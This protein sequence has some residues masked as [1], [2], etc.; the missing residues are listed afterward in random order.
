MSMVFRDPLLASSDKAT[1]FCAHLGGRA[2]LLRLPIVRDYIPHFQQVC[3]LLRVKN[4]YI[5]RTSLEEC[6]P[7]PEKSSSCS[8]VNGETH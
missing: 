3:S 8:C 5:C 1:P 2:R 7:V 4:V 6:M